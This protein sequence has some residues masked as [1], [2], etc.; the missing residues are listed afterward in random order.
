MVNPMGF[1]SD[2]KEKKA[3]AQAAEARYVQ[4]AGQIATGDKNLMAT[5]L[6]Q[7]Q[8][9]P[10]L[11]NEVPLE[12]RQLI[13]AEAFRSCADVAL[14]DD[15]LTEQEEADLLAVG[16]ALGIDTAALNVDFTDLLARLVVAKVN[17]GRLDVIAE[18]ARL[19]PKP[20]EIVHLQTYGALMKEVAIRQ[21]Q[22]GYGGMSF[23]VAKGVSF[24]T[25]QVRGKSVVVGS[26]M[27]VDDTGILT[28]SSLRVTF[29][30]DRKT[31]DIPF[32]KL[33]GLNV[34]SDGVTLQSSSR[35][36]AVLVRLNEGY[37]EVVAA[38][39]NAAMQS[40]L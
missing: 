21:W 7:L 23:R 17:D 35:Q 28:V 8:A 40:T 1:L 16:D 9:D 26:E 37:G 15:T 11:G 39:I 13:A 2:R 25:G 27:H 20:G 10:N 4:V 5:A 36:N 19:L 14:A 30:G 34:F 38:T 18:P 12:R 31:V 6:G 33:V 29:L 32:T 22:G 24:R 3:A